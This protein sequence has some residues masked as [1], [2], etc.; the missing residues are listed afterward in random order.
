MTKK[1]IRDYVISWNIRF[2]VDRWWRKKYNIAYN[3]LGHRESNFLDQLIEWEEDKLFSEF[4]REEYE[5][6]TGNWL[7]LKE[8]ETIE[9]SIESLKNEF[10]DLDYGGQ[11]D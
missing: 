3:S 5:P 1:E 2:P 9:D 7:K 11:D 6:N 8:P 10:K 4:E